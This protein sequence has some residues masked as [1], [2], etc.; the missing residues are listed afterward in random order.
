MIWYPKILLNCDKGDA[1]KQP[2]SQISLSSI[3]K[4]SSDV[5]YTYGLYLALQ[6]WKWYQIP[7][8]QPDPDPATVIPDL[9]QIILDPLDPTDP[10]SHIPYSHIPR[11]DP[12]TVALV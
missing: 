1:I 4:C 11:H 12:N 2:L 3:Q 10:G 9:T 7:N 6:L 8:L 5:K